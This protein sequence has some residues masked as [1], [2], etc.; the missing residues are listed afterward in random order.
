MDGDRRVTA[1]LAPWPG[2]PR[3][4]SVRGSRASAR[5]CRRWHSRAV[6][7][8]SAVATGFGVLASRVVKPAGATRRSVG[9]RTVTL[10]VW[11]PNGCLRLCRPGYSMDSAWRVGC[12]SPSPTLDLTI[13]AGD[14]GPGACGARLQGTGV[15]LVAGIA[16]RSGSLG[17]CRR[18]AT[19]AL[20]V[21]RTVGFPSPVTRN[22][23]RR[24]A[25]P[26]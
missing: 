13:P 7:L 24:R 6:W 16:A 15:R 18:W 21:A 9:G 8:L 20:A 12:R 3:G 26:G 5:R 19:H 22:D 11:P 1:S 2:S 10:F 4:S 25:D 14:V 17:R 23:Q